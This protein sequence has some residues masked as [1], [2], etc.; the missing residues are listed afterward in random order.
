LTALRCFV[1]GELWR[2]IAAPSFDKLRTSGIAPRAWLLGV[3]AVQFSVENGGVIAQAR[4]NRTGLQPEV[5]PLRAPSLVQVSLG[6][7]R[8]PAIAPL[9]PGA[10]A[11]RVALHVGGE[12]LGEVSL[13]RDSLSARPP[14]RAFGHVYCR[15]LRE[16]GI[17][18]GCDLTEFASVA[19][20]GTFQRRVLRA[21][22][23]G[24]VVSYAIIF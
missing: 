21:I 12:P 23:V 11:A 15:W 8:L 24:D 3:A 17:E 16:G 1:D 2:E 5:L 19:E 14:P 18:P 4:V 22:A 13:A 6:D 7:A 9:E 20:G 10:A